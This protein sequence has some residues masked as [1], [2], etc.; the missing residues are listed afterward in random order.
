VAQKNRLHS[1]RAAGI[2]KQAFDAWATVQES[3]K[4]LYPFFFQSVNK[5]VCGISGYR[6]AKMLSHLHMPQNAHPPPLC[7]RVTQSCH[8]EKDP[9]KR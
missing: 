7:T 5:D 2:S 1:L 8:F 3:T 6:C 9:A 4:E